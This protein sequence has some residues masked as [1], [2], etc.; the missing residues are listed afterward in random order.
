[1]TTIE[2]WDH[3]FPP[4]KIRKRSKYL[5]GA[6]RTMLDEL[7][8]LRVTRGMTQAD[9]AEIMGISQQSI[10]KIESYD[11]NPTLDTLQRYANAIGAMIEITVRQ[12]D[13]ASY[14]SEP[15]RPMPRWE[16]FAQ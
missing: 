16:T 14:Q 3:L 15:D 2:D 8:Q 7:G 6:H 12:D 5:S 1:M 4:G 9:V 13:G 11:S 10:S